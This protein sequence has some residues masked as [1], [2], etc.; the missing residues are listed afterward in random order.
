MDFD[1]IE[2]VEEVFSKATFLDILDQD[3]MG[4]S[5]EAN[6]GFFGGGRPNGYE[7]FFLQN[8]QEPHLGVQ[9]HFTDFVQEERAGIGGF[10]DAHFFGNK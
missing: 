5:N 4:G 1:D 3:A 9:A 7:L 8:T 6:V 10:E 2:A